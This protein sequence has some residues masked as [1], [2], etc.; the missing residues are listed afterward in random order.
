MDARNFSFDLK[1]IDCDKCK[2]KIGSSFT[3]ICYSCSEYYPNLFKRKECKT[4]PKKAKPAVKKAVKKVAKK[5]SVK[6][7]K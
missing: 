1:K 2:N 6:K 3:D 4:M 5:A 7:S